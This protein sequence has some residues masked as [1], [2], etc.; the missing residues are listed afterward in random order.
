LKK[1]EKRPRC[2]V[3][4]GKRGGE[5]REGGGKNAI[6]VNPKEVRGGAGRI[7][8]QKGDEEGSR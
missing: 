5:R 6:E 2:D 7:G 1:K 4:G 8:N 3:V